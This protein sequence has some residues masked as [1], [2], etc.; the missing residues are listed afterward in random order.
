MFTFHL[1]K[2]KQV[3]AL[4]FTWYSHSWAW[5]FFTTPLKYSPGTNSNHRTINWPT[6]FLKN[7]W[8]SETFAFF[9]SKVFISKF[10]CFLASSTHKSTSLQYIRI[11]PPSNRAFFKSVSRKIILMS[12]NRLWFTVY[13]LTTA[14]W[15]W[16][17][18]LACPSTPPCLLLWWSH[19]LYRHLR[20]PL[21]LARSVSLVSSISAAPCA[22]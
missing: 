19:Y 14:I 17:T 22:K 20:A 6:N 18:V 9:F 12:S 11:S 4:I 21:D 3:L 7:C 8:T 5:T 2:F 13:F 16:C 15:S 10:P 1:Y